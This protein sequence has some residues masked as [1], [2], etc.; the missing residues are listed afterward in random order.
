[1]T[2]F[3]WING[4]ASHLGTISGSVDNSSVIKDNA[5]DQDSLCV[6]EHVDALTCA[7]VFKPLLGGNNHQEPIAAHGLAR[8]VVLSRSTTKPLRF[9]YNPVV[10]RIKACASA[11]RLGSFRWYD[12]V[13]CSACSA[14]QLRLPCSGSISN[15]DRGPSSSPEHTLHP[16]L[17][18]QDFK[19]RQNFLAHF[20]NHGR[21]LSSISQKKH[22]T[23][24]YTT[25]RWP[26]R[27]ARRRPPRRS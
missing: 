8:F 3:S 17:R 20:R 12:G 19:A 23:R 1:M 24:G 13:S 9:R 4:E 7:I 2:S 25:P 16:A 6:V 22:D 21:F 11:A 5:H 27:R 18:K 26:N 15:T 10:S 14:Q